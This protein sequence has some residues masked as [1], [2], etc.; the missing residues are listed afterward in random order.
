MLSVKSWFINKNFT[1]NQKA[2]LDTV[3]DYKIE[4]ET[5]KAY[6][7]NAET[8]YGCIKFWCPKSCTV[9]ISDDEEEARPIE[10]VM[11]EFSLTK[12][13][14]ENFALFSKVSNYASGRI[15]KAEMEEAIAKKDAGLK[16]NVRLV[17]FCKMAGIKITNRKYTTAT[18]IE[19]IQNA[20]LE[21]PAR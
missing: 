8:D 10:E 12:E 14:M 21:V 17:E 1:E 16:Y 9:E 4:K 15:T 18:L 5:E 11:T 3:Y 6:F 2:A 20:G 13:D 7:L 19:K